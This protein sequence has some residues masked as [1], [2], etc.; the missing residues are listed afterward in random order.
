ML[1]HMVNSQYYPITVLC[2]DHVKNCA[3]YGQQTCNDPTYAG[4]VKDNCAKTCNKCAC[5]YCLTQRIISSNILT[6][7]FHIL[8]CGII[9]I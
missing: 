8:T 5:K 9:H 1:R 7:L 3:D 6:Y 4:W 2:V